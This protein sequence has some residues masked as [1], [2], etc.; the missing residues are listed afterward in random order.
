MHCE[1]V[2]D[3]KGYLL[4]D[5]QSTNGTFLD[6]AEVKEAYLRAGQR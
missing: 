3:A 6:G 2:R 5:L 4:R 1:I